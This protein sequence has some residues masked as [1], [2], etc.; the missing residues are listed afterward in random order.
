MRHEE[1][2]CEADVGAVFDRRV[3]KAFTVDYLLYLRRAVIAVIIERYA[4]DARFRVIG[5]FD[6]QR[7]I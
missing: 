2:A 6:D 3:E 5:I 4:V 7:L 1:T